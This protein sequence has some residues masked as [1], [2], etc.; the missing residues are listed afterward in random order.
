[1]VRSPPNLESFRSS[2]WSRWT[3]FRRPSEWPALIRNLRRRTTSSGSGSSTRTIWPKKFQ[4]SLIPKINCRW[5]V[6]EI[7][8]NLIKRTGL[9]YFLLKFYN[10]WNKIYFF[11]LHFC[12]DNSNKKMKNENWF[13]FVAR[14]RP[15]L[16]RHWGWG[17]FRI[18]GWRGDL[19][20]RRILVAATYLSNLLHQG[21]IPICF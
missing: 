20:E 6:K 21:L 8:Y 14:G 4:I 2:D 11:K 12:W 1:M 9:K 10:F 17:R 15:P 3:D 16:S 19:K 18:R 5:Q 7:F 13:I